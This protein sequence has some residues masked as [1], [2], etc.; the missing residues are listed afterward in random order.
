[1]PYLGTFGL[2]FEKAI[3]LSEI[4]TLE[5]VKCQSLTHT[6]NF[7]IGSTFFK[8]PGSGPDLPYKGCRLVMAL[9]K[10]SY[11]FINPQFTQHTVYWE[12]FP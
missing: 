8:G 6:A 5:F 11:S 12:E 2:Q 9:H 3:A 4:N 10:Y 7:G 1:M